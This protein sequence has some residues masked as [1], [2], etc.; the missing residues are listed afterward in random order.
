VTGRTRQHKSPWLFTDAANVIFT[1][2]KK[3]CYIQTAP[4]PGQSANKPIDIDAGDEDEWDALDE[5]EG[6]SGRAR[7]QKKWIP[8]NIEPVFEEQPK[9]GLLADIL[10][11]IEDEMIKRP[12]PPSKLDSTVH[13][14]PLSTVNHS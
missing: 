7:R 10:L 9:W 14:L 4:K 13:S 3:R 2:A 12:M 8:D 6:L 1:S 11:E 5:V